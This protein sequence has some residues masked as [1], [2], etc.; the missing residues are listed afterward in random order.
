MCRAPRFEVLVERGRSGESLPR[1]PAHLGSYARIT[2]TESRLGPLKAVYRLVVQQSLIPT[3][4][5]VDFELALGIGTRRARGIQNI[6]Q[7]SANQ[8]FSIDMNNSTAR[9]D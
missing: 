4:P 9:R 5:G 2:G 8:R 7:V 3:D 1:I 6:S